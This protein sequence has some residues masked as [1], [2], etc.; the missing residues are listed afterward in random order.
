M[1]RI[2]LDSYKK[3]LIDHYK[4]E[5]DNNEICRQRRKDSLERQYTDELLNSI[6]D[7][8]Y[9]FIDKILELSSS[10]Y[11][12]YI[13]IPLDF[14]AD[15]SYLFLNLTGGWMSDTIVRD[16]D[17]NFYSVGLIRCAFGPYFIIEPSKVKYNEE[18]DIIDEDTFILSEIPNYSL[19][20]QCNKDILDSV[21]QKEIKLVLK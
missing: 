1:D 10:D 13:E 14:E 4:Y 9:R 16:S 2:S 18:E 6:I 8:T 3:Y 17:G 12:G 11:P 19:Y 5:C 20:I 15:I 7:G 21:R